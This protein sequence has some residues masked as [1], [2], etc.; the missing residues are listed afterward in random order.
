MG[1]L[2]ST[3]IQPHRDGADDEE[4][5]AHDE[6]AGSPALLLPA[7]ATAL[8][9][10]CVF[11][12]HVAAERRLEL[13]GRLVLGLALTPGCHSIGYVEHRGVRLVTW[14]ILAVIN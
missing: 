7:A 4:Q 2:N 8:H 11:A 3:C 9:R 6:P 13:G 1:K 14:N 10:R 12:R 5:A